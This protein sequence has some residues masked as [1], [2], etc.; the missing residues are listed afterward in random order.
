MHVF[1][2]VSILISGLLYG[3]IGCLWSLTAW[4]QIARGSDKWSEERNE[5]PP[6]CLLLAKQFIACPCRVSWVCPLLHL[7][8]IVPEPQQQDSF[9]DGAIIQHG[10]KSAFSLCRLDL[11]KSLLWFIMW[12][13]GHCTWIKWHIMQSGSMHPVLGNFSTGETFKSVEL[14]FFFLSFRSAITPWKGKERVPVKL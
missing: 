7:V 11:K 3:A 9:M 1:Q 2:T 6:A 8:P 5:R 13:K 12:A 10:S 4:W 14:F